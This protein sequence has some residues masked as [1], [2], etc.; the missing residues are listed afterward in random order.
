MPCVANPIP[1]PPSLGGGLSI[2]P[3]PAPPP[4][5]NPKLCCQLVVIPAAPPIPPFPLPPAALIAAA[6]V[7][8]A[9]L[10]IMEAYLDAFLSKCPKS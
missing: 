7:I 9:K 8:G 4:V 2:P 6:Q 3:L 1:A 10:A 5:S